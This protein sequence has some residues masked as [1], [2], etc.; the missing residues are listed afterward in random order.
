M[1]ARTLT[2]LVVACLA[3]PAFAGAA[4]R[5]NLQ[6]FNDVSKQVMTYSWFT[7]FDD[8]NATIDEG[9][10]TL[11][12]NV[13]MPYKGNEIAKR[14]AKVE[15]VTD[16]VNNIETLPASQFDDRLRYQVARA[17]YGHPAFW[18]Y[19]TRFDPPIH[20]VVSRGNVTLTGV[21]DNESDRTIARSLASNVLAFSVESD[22]KTVAEAKA[23]LEGI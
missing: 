19:A 5:K 23:D 22:L 4:E 18:N 15:G 13:T 9:V 14:V 2:A 11:T 7:I 1:R 17:I 10:V 16:V 8:V 21:V 12:G 3:M 20:I 6:V